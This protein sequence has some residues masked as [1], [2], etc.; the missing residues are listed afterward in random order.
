MLSLSEPKMPNFSGQQGELWSHNRLPL[1]YFIAILERASLKVSE[2]QSFPAPAA[3]G[4]S[5]R[6]IHVRQILRQTEENPGGE[7]GNGS[8]PVWFCSLKR[9]MVA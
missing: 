6:R 5:D 4:R 3:T 8:R 2:A 7:L 9:G 1:V